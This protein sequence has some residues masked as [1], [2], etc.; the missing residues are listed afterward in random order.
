[1]ERDAVRGQEDMAETPLSPMRTIS[2]SRIIGLPHHNHALT[3]IHSK[4]IPFLRSPIVHGLGRDSTGFDNPY[5]PSLPGIR[6]AGK[7]SILSL[8]LYLLSKHVNRT[9]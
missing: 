2:V 7:T 4:R 3:P 9:T 6:T 5:F 8:G 1:M